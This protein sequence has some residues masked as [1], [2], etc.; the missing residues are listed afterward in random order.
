M[1]NQGRKPVSERKQPG[2]K[3]ILFAPRNRLD[4]P[5]DLEKALKNQGLEY[6]WLD[7][8]RMAENGN[9][10]QYHWE[11]YRVPSGSEKPSYAAAD[12]TVRSGTLVL[13]VRSLEMGDAHR[14]FN[15]DRADRYL[16]AVKATRKEIAREARK[17]GLEV[18]DDTEEKKI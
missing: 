4:I 1:S 5:P 10:H 17:E 11:V 6:R 9:L 2:S 16:K 8:K 12:G 3:K 14:E 18:D 7:A 13:G 15:Q